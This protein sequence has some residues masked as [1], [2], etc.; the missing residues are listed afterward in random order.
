MLAIE[1]CQQCGYDL[2]LGETQCPNCTPRPIPNRAARQVSG[3]DLPTRSVRPIHSIRP[4]LEDPPP[5]PASTGARLFFELA[6]F[7]VLAALV[8]IALAWIVRLDR[9]VLVVP[10]KVV[11]DIDTITLVA[12]AGAAI[13]CAAGLAASLVWSCRWARR[14]VA[15]QVR[16]R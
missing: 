10:A 15:R 16:A 13:A 11:A 7:L 14:R 1:T 5:L 8:G 2:P 3:L 4:R 9:Y 12:G 6:S